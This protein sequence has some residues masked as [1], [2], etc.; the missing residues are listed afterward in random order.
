[1][2]TVGEARDLG[3]VGWVRNES[4]G[5]V[6]LEAQGER[7]ALESLL[8]WCHE[9]PPGARVTG[10]HVEWIAEIAGE[11]SFRVRS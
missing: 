5:A 9:G 1:M 8:A 6:L 4:D 2:C 3:L 10:V 11:T 7:P